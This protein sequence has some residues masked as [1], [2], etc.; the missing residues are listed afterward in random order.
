MSEAVFLA[1][2]SGTTRMKAALLD[3]RGRLRDLAGTDLPVRYPAD[4][5]CEMDP[6]AVWDALCGLTRLLAERS[7]ESWRDLAGLAIAGQGDGLWPLDRAG[8]PVRPAILWNDTRAKRLEDV[9]WPG[10][11]GFCA[12][13]ALGPLFPG[14]APALLLWLRRHEPDQHARTAH[15]VHCKDWLNYNLTGVIGTDFSDASTAALDV[16]E[17]RYVGELFE[18]LGLPGALALLPEPRPSA[19]PLGRVTRA[20]AERTGLPEG[21][22]VMAGALDVAAVAAGAGAVRPGDAVTVVGTTLC[23]EVVLERAQ[24]DPAD[25][26]GSTLCHVAPDR[27]LRLMATSS[28]TSSL[29]WAR[30][31][32]APDLTFARLE[33]ELAGIPPGCEGVLFQPYLHG[34]RAPF[35]NA[36]A[37]GGFYGLAARHTAMHLLR[38]AYEGLALAFC[39]CHHFLP[40][41]D[42]VVLAGGG[43]ASDLLCQLFADCLGRPTLRPGF[44]E[45]GLAGAA[46]LVWTGL[47]GTGPMH[48]EA[49]APA[50]EFAPEPDRHAFYGRLYALSLT[51]RTGLEPYWSSRDRLLGAHAAR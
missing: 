27:W 6:E 18:R 26:R 25:P 1:V 42:R 35:R 3:G 17:R 32:L 5:A 29:D 30:R 28:G 8:R 51:L 36:L 24:V 23:N 4:G 13:H 46:G 16:L 15:L 47:G 45:L 44:P 34:E 48:L 31:L 49:Q 2:D 10:L 50:R 43:A 9:D 39:D 7:P 38:A 41:V 20:A 19:A 14:A 40:P 11:A 33:A 21:L 22:P 12:A 37:C